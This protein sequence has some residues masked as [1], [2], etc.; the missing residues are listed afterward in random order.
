MAMVRWK[1]VMRDRT[2]KFVSFRD[3]KTTQASGGSSRD[4]SRELRFKRISNSIMNLA[5]DDEDDL[6]QPAI[7]HHLN[8]REVSIS[9]GDQTLDDDGGIDVRERKLDNDSITHTY[10]PPFW[11]VCK[12]EIDE[13]I[14]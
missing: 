11:L 13:N 7:K 9:S 3:G 14:K 8:E 6:E 1:G 5:D 10:Q 12:D 2:D 4:N